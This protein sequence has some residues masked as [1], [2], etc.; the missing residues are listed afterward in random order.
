MFYEFHD[1]SATI[2]LSMQ[3]AQAQTGLSGAAG[4]AP[5]G[6]E[7]FSNSFLGVN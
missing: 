4:E 3:H 1:G 2:F 5:M 7:K 6:R